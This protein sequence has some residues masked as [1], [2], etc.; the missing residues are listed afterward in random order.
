MGHDS[1]ARRVVGQPVDP[2]LLGFHRRDVDQSDRRQSDFPAGH[3]PDHPDD[4]E[5]CRKAPPP[6]RGIAFRSTPTNC[7]PAVQ[8]VQRFQAEQYHSDLHETPRTVRERGP[9]T[10]PESSRAASNTET[11]PPV[12]D[13]SPVNQ[14][15][16]RL[17]A[18]SRTASTV[19]GE[20]FSSRTTSLPPRERI[21]TNRATTSSAPDHAHEPTR[22]SQQLGKR[23][24]QIIAGQRGQIANQL[25]GTLV[26]RI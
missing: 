24:F 22:E 6:F 13:S 25:F 2:A 17:S 8:S 20:R 15:T 11:T 7:S 4:S 3:H 1:V 26:S 5:R 9:S 14:R 16:L 10:S 23:S 19:G 21:S 18:P 12:A